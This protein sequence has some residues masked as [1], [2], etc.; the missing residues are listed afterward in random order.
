[1]TTVETFIKKLTRENQWE[2]E[3][4]LQLRYKWGYIKLDWSYMFTDDKS[5]T[6]E[7]VVDEPWITITKDSE[8]KED[9]ETIFNWIANLCDY[10]EDADYI[11]KEYLLEELANIQQYAK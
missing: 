2:K 10:I 11:E 1:M 3:L 7:L 8:E 4:D 5:R 6:I 9:K